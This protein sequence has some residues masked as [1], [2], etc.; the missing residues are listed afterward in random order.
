MLPGDAEGGLQGEEGGSGGGELDKGMALIRRKTIAIKS[1][2]VSDVL[3]NNIGAI[4][5]S[6]DKFQKLAEESSVNDVAL[7]YQNLKENYEQQIEKLQARTLK[8][9]QQ[10][11]ELAQMVQT[12]EGEVEQLDYAKSQYV[13]KIAEVNTEVE[14]AESQI[15]ESRVKEHEIVVVSALI[16]EKGRLAEE[17]SQL[18]KTC[19][20]E[21]AKLDEQL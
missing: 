21:K 4:T 5:E 13:D 16:E 17:K 7:N 3:M 18:K 10:R 1:D 6:V 14:A 8:Q 11:D 9:T 2:N 19:R 20:E 15:N 12:L